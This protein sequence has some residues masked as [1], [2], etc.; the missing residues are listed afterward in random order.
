MTPLLSRSTPTKSGD[1]NARASAFYTGRSDTR[2]A[3]ALVIPMGHHHRC[4]DVRK[5]LLDLV[6]EQ[7][8][9]SWKFDGP[10]AISL[11]DHARWDSH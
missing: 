2:V 3:T 11:N 5:P 4:L 10:P 7:P 1:G 6:D 9:H 8:I